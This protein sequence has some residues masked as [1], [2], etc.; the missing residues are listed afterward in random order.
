MPLKGIF[1]HPLSL[2]GVYSCILYVNFYNKM[3]NSTYV[4][5]GKKIVQQAWKIARTQKCPLEDIS[6]ESQRV[7]VMKDCQYDEMDQLSEPF[8][9]L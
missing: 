2:E 3:Q 1:G 4:S 9:K 8:T 6:E 5:T 7:W